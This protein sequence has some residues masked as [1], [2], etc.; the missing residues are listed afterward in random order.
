VRA[1]R[2]GGALPTVFAYTDS[3]NFL[4]TLVAAPAA[5][6]VA[7]VGLADLAGRIGRIW[8]RWTG[9]AVAIGCVA[10]SAALTHTQLGRW[11]DRPD[12]WDKFQ[13]FV[14]EVAADAVGA[15][16]KDAQGTTTAFFVPEALRQ[17]LVFRYLTLEAKG[18]IFGY[19]GDD[20]VS[21]WPPSQAASGIPE[22]NER[23]AVVWADAAS[24]A[25]ARAAAPE[26]EVIRE[27]RGPGG[28]GRVAVLLRA[29][30]QSKSPPNGIRNPNVE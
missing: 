28:R 8:R 14:V 20:W 1:W 6:A 9:W 16:E 30:R 7:G 25:A 15:A 5:A 26:A 29:G 19:A 17:G 3:P 10:G 23:L 2:G 22:R 18:E 21:A 27:Y 11:Q 4:R 13:G 24:L 12:V